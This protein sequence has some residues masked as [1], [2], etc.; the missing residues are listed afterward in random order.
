M[1]NIAIVAVGYNR[2]APLKRLLD[3]IENAKYQCDDIHLYI[4]IDNSGEKVVENMANE[5]VWTHGTK[6]VLTYPSRLGL[7]NHILKCGNLLSDYDAI[8][9][10]EDDL[11]VSE[12]FYEYAQVT[13]EFYQHDENVAG[14]SLYNY[15]WNE[16]I[17]QPFCADLSEYNSYFIQ[18]AQS[19]GQIWMKNQWKDFIRW[20]DKNKNE[21][22]FDSCIPSNILQWKETSW[23]KYHII[24]CVCE[25]KY[26]VQPYN[27]FATC[28]S[29]VGEHC[30][31]HV[32]M[33][34]VPLYQGN[35]LHLN[36]PKFG[37]KSAVYYDAFFERD[38]RFLP[39]DIIEGIDNDKIVIDLYGTKSLFGENRF[40]LS[41]KQLNYKVVDSFGLQMRPQERN[42]FSKVKGI[43]I[44]LY[45]MN[46]PEKNSF[47]DTKVAIFRYRNNLYDHTKDIIYCVMESLMLRLRSL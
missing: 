34:Q 13:V 1:K 30:K 25:N 19:W 14:I 8:I 3:S 46:S 16:N 27:S 23:K 36:L 47:E 24:Y 10:L 12:W 42:V 21:P 44:Y 6:N 9:V 7:R 11:V 37:D 45:D 18:L 38:L 32:N 4:S 29:E 28:F 39:K 35:S 17:N 15:Q 22:F 31:Y 5:F 33:L 40:L 2:L 41:T 20:Y 43:E 26:F